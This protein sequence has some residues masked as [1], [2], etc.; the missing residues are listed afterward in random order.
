MVPSFETAAFG[1][2]T[3]EVSNVVETQ[4]GYHV[5]KV[6]DKKEAGVAKFDEVKP[7]IQEYLKNMKIQKGLMDY[8]AQLKEKAKIE[9]IAN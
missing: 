1:L 4:F 6:T 7:K 5:I 3:G 2:K 8:I 9:K